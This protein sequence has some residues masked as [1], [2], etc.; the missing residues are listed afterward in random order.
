MC[1]CGVWV[2]FVVCA[3]V[4]VWCL[5]VCGVCG[6]VCVYV[7]VCVGVCVCMCGCV[8]VC[9]CCVCMLVSVCMCVRSCLTY[10]HITAQ[11]VQSK[12]KGT[13][14]HFYLHILQNPKITKSVTAGSLRSNT[15]KNRR[16]F[17]PL[18]VKTRNV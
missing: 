6:C 1:V 16:G 7:C 11:V 4:C 8:C 3:C 10:I 12:T 9:L 5:Y 18:R 13:G 2:Y 14:T 17:P 15:D